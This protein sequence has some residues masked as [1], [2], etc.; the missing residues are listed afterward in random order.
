MSYQVFCISYAF[1]FEFI[2]LTVNSS[3]AYV[4]YSNNEI[5]FKHEAFHSTVG[6]RR[7]HEAF[8][9]TVGIECNM[10]LF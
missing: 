10:Y 6:M 7:S 1:S 5:L 3:W 9:S 2:A 4:Y 8:H